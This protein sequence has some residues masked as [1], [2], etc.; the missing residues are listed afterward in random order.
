[1]PSQEFLTMNICF[2]STLLI[3][4]LSLIMMFY[5]INPFKMLKSAGKSKP[6]QAYDEQYEI[7]E[8]EPSKVVILRIPET[9]FETPVTSFAY[10][11]N[12]Q[13]AMFNGDEL[14]YAVDNKR[15]LE[16]E[17]ELSI[18]RGDD[19]CIIN[20]VTDGYKAKMADKLKLMEIERAIL[21]SQVEDYNKSVEDSIIKYGHSTKEARKAIGWS[22]GYSQIPQYRRPWTGLGSSGGG[23]GE[24]E[25]L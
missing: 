16:P 15:Q 19:I 13:V 21:K 9:G 2:G 11:W 25:E 14:V 3:A 22:S 6:L 24:E 1:M 8:V 12:G 18:L 23:Y 4:I 17:D 5:N 10:F 7:H 20:V